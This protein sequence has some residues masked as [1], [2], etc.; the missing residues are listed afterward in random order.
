MIAG[1]GHSKVIRQNKL[2]GK[3]KDKPESNRYLKESSMVDISDKDA[4]CIN[5]Q[6][7]LC[8]IHKFL[9]ER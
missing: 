9:G 3:L 2:T 4:E 1:F 6:N 5:D 8:V 7:K